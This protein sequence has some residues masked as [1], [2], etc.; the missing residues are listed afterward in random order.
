MYLALSGTTMPFHST[1]KKPVKSSD[2]V[3][4]CTPVSSYLLKSPSVVR[5]I[6]PT[7]LR[8]I[9][10]V[11]LK[12]NG[13][14]FKHKALN[15]TK[16]RP[17][18]SCVLLFCVLFHWLYLLTSFSQFSS[19]K[20]LTI[21]AN[22]SWLSVVKRIRSWCLDVKAAYPDLSTTGQLPQLACLC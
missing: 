16:I 22:L 4:S 15:S 11:L 19:L 5:N 1:L 6:S 9:S 14:R 10:Q 13:N 8:H 18:S 7:W 2:F 3:D 17:N 20:N 12:L 21:F